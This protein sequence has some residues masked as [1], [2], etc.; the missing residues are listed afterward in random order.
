MFALAAG[1]DLAIAVVLAAVIGTVLGALARLE[2]RRPPVVHAADCRAASLDDCRA[3]FL[4][5][6]RTR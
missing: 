3:A 6:E 5:T 4:A 1:R 2:D